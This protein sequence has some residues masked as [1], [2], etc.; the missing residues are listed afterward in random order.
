MRL[1]A[2]F[3]R[4]DVS[5]AREDHTVQALQRPIINNWKQDRCTARAFN[6]LRIRQSERE[7]V[8]ARVLRAECEA[9]ERPPSACHSVLKHTGENRTDHD[10]RASEWS[11]T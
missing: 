9:D 8:A 7:L 5:A 3:G 10:T 2:V 6:R 1:R 11:D 4:V